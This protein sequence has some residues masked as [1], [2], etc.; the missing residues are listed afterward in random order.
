[1]IETAQRADLKNE[2]SQDSS[3]NLFFPSSMVFKSALEGSIFRECRFIIFFNG[4]VCTWFVNSQMNRPAIIIR[5][6]KP[7]AHLIASNVASK[8]TCGNVVN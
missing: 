1:M 5:I 4:L 3:I 2:S 8:Y 6:L 7:Y